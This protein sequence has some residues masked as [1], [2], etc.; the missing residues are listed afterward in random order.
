MVVNNKKLSKKYHV[1]HQIGEALGPDHRSIIS[2]LHFI[3]EI[4]LY[5]LI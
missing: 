2:I 4:Q 1:S 3:K 5:N